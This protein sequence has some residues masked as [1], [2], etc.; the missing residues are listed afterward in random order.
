MLR[1]M[2]KR[3]LT[4]LCFAIPLGMA[5]AMFVQA[6]P[7]L[8]QPDSQDCQSCH[9][10]TYTHWEASAHGQA[11]TDPAFVEAWDAQGQPA[12]CL[13]CHATERIVDGQTILEEGV[14]CT[15]CHAPNSEDHPNTVMPTNISSRLCGDCHLDTFKEFETSIHGQDGLNC[16]NCHKSHNMTLRSSNVQEL[17]ATCHSETSHFYGYSRHAQEG[18]LCVDCHVRVSDTQIG[19][20]HG[21]RIHTFAVDL[22][23]CNE[24]H[25]Q[26]LHNPSDAMSNVPE[27]P[28]QSGIPPSENISAD[29]EEVS[30]LGFAV[31]AALIGMAFGMVLAPWMERF[32]NQARDRAE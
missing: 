27:A 25:S 14:Q 24:C 13:N 10:I 30:P 12:S 7:S 21:Q 11:L 32:Y 31:V 19:E 3:L 1:M 2:I 26:D 6:S 28:L 29:I 5:S 15:V 4:G 8:Q 20:G 23:T 16:V 17:C 18:L 22:Q 9:T